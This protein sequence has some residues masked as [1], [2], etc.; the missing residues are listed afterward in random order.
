MPIKS[1]SDYNFD[2][3]D[4]GVHSDPWT[5]RANGHKGAMT[6][7]PPDT[8]RITPQDFLAQSSPDISRY[9]T[10]SVPA[11]INLSL[12][13]DETRKPSASPGAEAKRQKVPRLPALQRPPSFSFA[14]FA[15]GST[16]DDTDPLYEYFPLGLDDWQEPVDAVYRPHVVHHIALPSSKDAFKSRSKRYFSD[17]S[18][19]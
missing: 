5:M 15:G 17:V 10:Q 4:L 18:P 1:E 14:T 3:S 9:A 11:P 12:V 6:A 8:F 19:G 13:E 7:L 2:F 16:E